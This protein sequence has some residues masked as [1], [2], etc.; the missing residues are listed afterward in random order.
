ML[1]GEQSLPE[2]IVAPDGEAVNRLFG[3]LCQRADSWLAAQFQ[4]TLRNIQNDWYI[5]QR[6]SILCPTCGSQ[7]L[8]RKGWRSR[9]VSTSRGK[10]RV[11]VIQV[12]CKACDRT[13]RPLNNVLGL[14]KSRRF[15]DEI[16]DKAAFLGIQ[17][18]F[19][20]AANILSRLT[21]G[22]VSSEGVRRIVAQR[23]SRLQLPA[24]I[25]GQTVL[26]DSTK[27]KAGHKERGE[28]VHLAITAEP[29]PVR[30][31]RPTCRKQLVHLH[32]GTSTK[33]RQ[34]LKTSGAT[35]VVHDGGENLDDCATHLQRCRW[36]L[37]HQL[38]HYLWQDGVPHAL[39]GHFQE[40]MTQIVSDPKQGP[41]R[42]RRWKS[43]LTA[44]GLRTAAGHLE[45]AAKETFTYLK[46]PFAYIDTSPLEREMREL[47]RR[48]DIGTR[49]SPK[50]LENVLKLMFHH[51]LNETCG[52]VR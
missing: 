17:V 20:R 5:R 29:G 40:A 47:N 33:L 3:L 39:R 48:A 31:G 35:H 43:N 28:P 32:V 1:P 26:V 52:D 36:H 27:V 12:R 18:S 37:G 10:L 14:P 45:N 38:K 34:R 2:A 44:L 15:L 22:S 21:Q 30:H 19:A 46:E 24:P 42:F 11:Q 16:S 41:K 4:A 13:F 8:I 9:V 25:P 49:W 51:R 7:R 6:E 23:A 50:G